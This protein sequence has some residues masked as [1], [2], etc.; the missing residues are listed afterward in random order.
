MNFTK[1]QFEILKQYDKSFYTACY[2]KFVRTSGRQEID[3]VDAIY[4][5]VFNSTKGIAGGCNHC[6]YEAYKKLGKLYFEDKAKYEEKAKE[7]PK[8]ADMELIQP[9]CATTS[10]TTTKAATKKKTAKKTTK[11]K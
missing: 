1:E 10:T 5:K 4:K 6:I 8:E 7:T 9:E 11:K 2:C 3:N